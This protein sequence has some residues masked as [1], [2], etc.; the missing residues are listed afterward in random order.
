[1]RHAFIAA[2]SAFHTVKLLCQVMGISRRGYYD[3]MRRPPS[4][5]ELSNQ[6]LLVEIR[7]I[8]HANREVY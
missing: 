6:E 7:R 8:F 1:M 3:W 5:Q 2:Q 4:A